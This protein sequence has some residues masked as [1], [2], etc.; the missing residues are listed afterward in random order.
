MTPYDSVYIKSI[1][2]NS[3]IKNYRESGLMTGIHILIS[4]TQGRSSEEISRDFDNDLELVCVWID[5]LV[6]INWVIETQLTEAG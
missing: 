2:N 3:A 6:G 5:Y 1:L 4:L